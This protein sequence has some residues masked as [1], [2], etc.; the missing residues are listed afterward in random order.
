[1]SKNPQGQIV[2][3]KGF[4][5]GAAT[6]SYQ[7]EGAWQEDGKGESIWDRFS[8]TPGKIEDGDT[9]KIA[10]DHYH[11]WQDDINIM[12]EIGLKAYRFSV[13]WP[14]ILPRGRGESN[15]KGIDF[16]SR[17]VDGLLEVNIEPYLTLY[18]WDLPQILQDEG[19]WPARSTA[20][21]FVE[22]A[23]LVSKALGDRVKNWTTFNEPRVSAWIGHFEGRHA[24][25]H[26]DQSEFLKAAHH[27]LLAHGKAVPVIRE[28]VTNANVG[29]V[30]DFSPQYA[31]SASDADLDL[32]RHEDGV[33]NRWYVE[34]IAGLGYPKDIV[35]DFQTSMEFV[36]ENDME[37]ISQPI[38]FLGINFYSR[39]VQ[40][41]NE[42]P[43]NYPKTIVGD[44]WKSLMGW[45]VAPQALYDLLIRLEYTYKFPKLYITENGGA[46][47][48]VLTD[49][50]DV[51][52]EERRKYI[53]LHL[54][55]A[56]KAIQ[57][58]VNLKGYFV[59]SL[60]DNFEW[61]K[62][63]AMRF[64]I[65]YIDFVSLK[66]TLKASAK[67]YSQVIGNNGFNNK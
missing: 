15:Q 65:T 53:E 16:Y 42:D 10:A 47:P 62:G 60:M 8:A 39:S 23:E 55:Q 7:I 44:D 29:M 4:I 28:N 50:G 11:L 56:I 34:P 2:F 1:M 6:S 66:R 49:E 52:D 13:S 3:P 38:D 30:L 12:Q 57:A 19:G 67:W 36:Q 5:W 59:W 58:G 63:Y 9:G 35:E 54:T 43:N 64:G 20:D 46:F 40:G 45:E 37:V 26:Q 25:G 14:R 51:N 31:A 21:A 17:L 22:Y 41:K 24:P 32:M 61:D 27:L 33:F 18:H 48:D